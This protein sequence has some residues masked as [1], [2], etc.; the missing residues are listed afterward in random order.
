MEP[1]ITCLDEMK[2]LR[3]PETSDIEIGSVIIFR[4]SCAMANRFEGRI[5]HR[6]TRI[7]QID[8]AP[9][10][11]TK[12]DNWRWADGCYIK[13]DAVEALMVDIKEDVFP[14]NGELR[15]SVNAAH[16][17]VSRAESELLTHEGLLHDAET[18]LDSAVT[19]LTSA[20][21]SL[22]A[23]IAQVN[24]TES[25]LDSAYAAYQ[26]ALAT[27]N[28]AADRYDNNPTQGNYASWE[29]AHA[30]Y[31]SADS[32]YRTAYREYDSA[33]NTYESSRAAYNSAD[34]TYSAASS[35]YDTT[36]SEYIS[37]YGSVYEVAWNKFACWVNV[38]IRQEK[39]G[40]IPEHE[41]SP[42]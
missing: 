31:L 35:S 25:T 32:V 17:V 5:L 36:Y 41:C 15:D 6:V 23:A 34:S 8:G 13:H 42:A 38:A 18:A 11:W 20:T 26:S 22:S 33:Y 1:D 16:R 19:D 30:L 29:I 2:F 10:Y 37:F 4:F 7:T 28:A 24:S 40:E 14:E 9:F 12:G 27:N 3:E 39:S 21:S